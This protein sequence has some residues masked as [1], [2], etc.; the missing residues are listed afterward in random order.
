VSNEAEVFLVRWPTSRE[1][2]NGLAIDLLV[3][4]ATTIW[5]NLLR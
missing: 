1:M 5:M 4:P 3:G 2:K